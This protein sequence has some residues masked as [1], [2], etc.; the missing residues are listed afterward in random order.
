MTQRAI[1][2]AAVYA[3]ATYGVVWFSLQLLLALGV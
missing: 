2:H 3:F 1:G